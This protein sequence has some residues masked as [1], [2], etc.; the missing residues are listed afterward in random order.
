M[1]HRSSKPYDDP[2]EDET[3]KIVSDDAG[4]SQ[5]EHINQK[6]LLKIKKDFLKVKKTKNQKSPL[7]H[8]RKYN[9][10]KHVSSL[11]NLLGLSLI[12]I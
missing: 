1:G 4:S 10:R 9:Q 11:L 12:H 6:L 5:E 3:T 8:K 2:F 7:K